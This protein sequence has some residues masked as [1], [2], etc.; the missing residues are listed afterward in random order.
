MSPLQAILLGLLQG[1][2]E[3]VPV[4]SS[5]HLVLIPWLLGWP[6]PS[7][8]YDTMVHL[9][10]LT[11]VVV[12]LRREIG[13]LLREGF[14]SLRTL[15][16]QTA[17]ARLFWLV[18]VSAIPGAL[19]GY[20]WADFFEQLFGSPRATSALLIVTGAI[21]LLSERLGQ[22][23]ITLEKI[24][25]GRAFI[26]GLAQGC[27]IAPGLSRS[28]ATI[29]AGLLCGLK[30]EEAARFSFLMSIP[31]IA[32]AASV[33]L[34]ELSSTGFE[35]SQALGLGLGFIAALA[36]GYVA[37]RFLLRYLQTHG[38]KAFTYYCWTVGLLG[39]VLSLIASAR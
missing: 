21:L 23:S 17:E 6:S 38:L 4:S 39:L 30:R 31:I 27:A 5:G 13:I 28:G 9:G 2:T 11:A 10:T 25:L 20:I 24:G 37:V 34:L 33:Q 8:T 7:L 3:F 15:K 22:R 16:P 1:F 14:A 12:Y 26:M 18:I 19:M 35:I 29:A 32:G 36:S